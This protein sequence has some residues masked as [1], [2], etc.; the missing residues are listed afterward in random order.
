[1]QRPLDGFRV[2]DLSDET[3]FLCGRML[4]EL[5][6]DVIKVE[7]PGGDPARLSPPY[8]GGV[9]DPERA[10]TWLAYNASKRGVTLDLSRVEGRALFDR[11]C[12]T[13]DALVE[14]YDPAALATLKLDWDTLH[15]AHPRL[16][17]CSITPF[18]RT[19]PYAAY[20]GSD[21]TAT[22]MGGNMA[23]TGDPDRAPLRCTMPSSYYHGGAEAASGLLVALIA[24]GVI[25]E[26]Q[27]VDVSLQ[28]AMVST[29]MTG[30]SQWAMDRRDRNR[31]GASY[32]VGRTLQR[33]VWRCK[34][35]F[36]SY[37]LRG[38][39]ARIPGLQATERWLA[40][41]RIPAPAWQGRDWKAYNH[42]DLTQ[43]QVD[44]LSAPLQEL[45][46]Q[47]PMRELFDESV[48]RGVM[49]APV[50]DSREIASSAQLRAREFFVEVDDPKRGLRYELPA[51]FARMSRYGTDVR[52]PAPLLGEHDA[53]VYGSI[54]VSAAELES[55][56]RA[57]VV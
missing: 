40:E 53:E 6:A 42:N 10:V 52:G 18:G 19:G 36:V 46:L 35:G 33:E 15:A 2:L 23:L 30:A 39:P 21:I 32:P 43:E 9:A 41:E 20:R 57:G 47:K 8:V 55:L 13:A 5:G 34:D 24:R 28:A 27:H 50:N 51:R 14:T 4:A 56:R 22:A 26:G 1:M 49:L 38:G 7:P 11:L 17:V 31:T 48:R 29:I 44:A 37:A 25:G 3:G 54:G 12:A 45:F 16:V